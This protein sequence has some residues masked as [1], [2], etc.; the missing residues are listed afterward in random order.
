VKERKVTEPGLVEDFRHKD[1]KTQTNESEEPKFVSVCL[2]SWWFSTLEEG[3]G[4]F[5]GAHGV[6]FDSF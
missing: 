2:V 4:R 1:T 5:G 3:D 6:A